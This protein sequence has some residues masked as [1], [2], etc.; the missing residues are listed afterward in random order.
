MEF[1]RN[2]IHRFAR[3]D[4]VRVV[5]VRNRIRAFGYGGQ[6]SSVLPGKLVAI[7]VTERVADL[8]VSN[9]YFK[10]FLFENHE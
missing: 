7:A 4:A 1:C 8:I 2:S 9:G 5:G 10:R 6:P 3:S